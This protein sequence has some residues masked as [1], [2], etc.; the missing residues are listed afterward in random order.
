MASETEHKYLVIS[1]E[2]LSLA[3]SSHIIEQGY[4]N[5]DK[6]RTV[7]VRILD[8][9]GFITIKGETVGDTRE[10]YEYQIPLDDARALLR[11]C[12]GVVVSK[13]RYVVPYCGFEWEVDIFKGGLSPLRVAEIELPVSSHDYPLPPFVGKEVTGDVRFYNSALSSEG[14]SQIMPLISESED[15]P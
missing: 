1:D 10:E 9:K 2:Y 14:I 8:D 3:K 7:R 6:R 15:I 4:L 12:D 11:L 13:T 5:R